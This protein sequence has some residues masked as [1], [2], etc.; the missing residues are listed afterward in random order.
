MRIS[1]W[2]SDVCSSDLTRNGHRISLADGGGCGQGPRVYHDRGSLGK[3]PRLPRTVRTARVTIAL[4]EASFVDGR[5]ACRSLGSRWPLP[6]SSPCP[7][8]GLA[9]PRSQIGRAS[10]WEQRGQKV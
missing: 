7:L 6:H 3:S 5:Q 10:W 9:S 2:S 4:A 8:P 1:D